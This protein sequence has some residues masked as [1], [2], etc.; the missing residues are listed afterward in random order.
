MY[1]ASE[2]VGFLDQS[3]NT[4]CTI[5]MIGRMSFSVAA[6]F[7]IIFITRLIYRQA[8]APGKYF[9]LVHFVFKN[10]VFT[11]IPSLVLSIFLLIIINISNTDSEQ[12][13]WR[14]VTNK[15]ALDYIIYGTTFLLPNIV[16][17]VVIV[18]YFFLLYRLAS[19]KWT[20]FLLFSITSLAFS[21]YYISIKF[22][23]LFNQDQDMGYYNL[24]MLGQPII[25]GVFYI[26]VYLRQKKKETNS[27]D[28]TIRGS[29]GE[30]SFIDDL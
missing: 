13:C 12:F 16:T 10:I 26:V 14:I 1:S 6:N 18:I 5:S 27:S 3:N 7:W 22:Y 28:I 11:Y 19:G 29:D 2:V 17:S 23:Q 15:E 30:A 4:L 20:F 9:N 8:L 25:Y 24:A 21:L